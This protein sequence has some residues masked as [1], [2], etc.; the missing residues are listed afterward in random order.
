LNVKASNYVTQKHLVTHTLQYKHTRTCTHTHA[1]THMHTYTCTHTP[2]H[3]HT[4]TQYTEVFVV[5][6]FIKLRGYLFSSRAY[7]KLGA[8]KISK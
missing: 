2:T 1:H 7:S 5:N 6:A 3:R 8:L 4:H